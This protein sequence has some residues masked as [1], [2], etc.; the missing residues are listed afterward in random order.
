[1]ESHPSSGSLGAPWGL[2]KKR[3]LYHSYR[4][5]LESP[6]QDMSEVCQQVTSLERPED[7]G[8]GAPRTPEPKLFFLP[9]AD[10]RQAVVGSASRQF[11]SAVR[12]TKIYLD[13]R[14][15]RN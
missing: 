11:A 10:W 8:T 13:M 6:Q 9:E 7:R 2:L 1:M 3:D 14:A 5:W 15:T 4:I 12:P